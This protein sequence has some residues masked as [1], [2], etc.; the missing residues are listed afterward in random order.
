MGI[1][2]PITEYFKPHS[3]TIKSAFVFGSVAKGTDT[4]SSDIDLMVIGNNL[5]YADLYDAAQNVERR[6]CRKVNPLFVSPADWRRKTSE[7]G[8]VFSKIRHSPKIFVIGSE[9]DLRT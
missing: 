6:V 8:S 9:R 3:S 7:P 4:A 2:G 1:V 5:N